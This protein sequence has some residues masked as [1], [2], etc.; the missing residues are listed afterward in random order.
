MLIRG[1]ERDRDAW[2]PNERVMSDLRT[3]P[4]E[5]S[6]HARCRMECRNITE[7]EISQVLKNG[8][9]N[10]SKSDPRDEPCKSYAVEA[11]V[12]GYKDLRVIFGACDSLTRVITVIDL[13]VETINC[14]CP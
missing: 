2:L 5:Y 13:S 6:N 12:D 10:F 11:K 4:L 14:T 1:S 3:F 9:V 8:E 7:S